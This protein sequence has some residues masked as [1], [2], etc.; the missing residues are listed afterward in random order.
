MHECYVMKILETKKT[1]TT[2]NRDMK[3]KDHVRKTQLD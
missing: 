1:K 3:L 2:K